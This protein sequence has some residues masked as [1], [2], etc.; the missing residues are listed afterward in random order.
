MAYVGVM[1]GVEVEVDVLVFVMEGVSV[2]GFVFV[3]VKVPVG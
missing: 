1:L 2:G 3:G